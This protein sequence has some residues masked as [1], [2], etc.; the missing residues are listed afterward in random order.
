MHN[1]IKVS[2]SHSGALVKVVI[3][4]MADSRVDL[5]DQSSFVIF[6]HGSP[7]FSY[8][9]STAMMNII[10]YLILFSW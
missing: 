4:E 9:F 7:L 5:W 10:K 6:M 3:T 1:D 8:A 2:F